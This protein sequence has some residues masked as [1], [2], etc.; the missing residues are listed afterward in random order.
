VFCPFPP[1]S[2]HC[3]QFEGQRAVGRFSAPRG[4]TLLL[5]TPQHPKTYKRAR[6]REGPRGT[7]SGCVIHSGREGGHH[8]GCIKYKTSARLLPLESL[9]RGCSGS[10]FSCAPGP[11]VPGRSSRSSSPAR[12][13]LDLDQGLLLL[14]RHST[15]GETLKHYRKIKVD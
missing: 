3:A 11:A 4:E 13:S 9:A 5:L 8:T 1:F 7:G 6:G 12:P 14:S 10:K 15:G 2:G